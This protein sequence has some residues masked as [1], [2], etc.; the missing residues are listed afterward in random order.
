MVLLLSLYFPQFLLFN[1]CSQTFFCE[2]FVYLEVF[3]KTDYSLWLPFISCSILCFPGAIPGN[4][5]W[6]CLSDFLHFCLDTCSLFSHQSWFCYSAFVASFVK[7][8]LLLWSVYSETF[9]ILFCSG[10]LV[11][12]FSLHLCNSKN[13]NLF[14]QSCFCLQFRFTCFPLL[15]MTGGFTTVTQPGN[16][17]PAQTYN[18]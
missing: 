16:K 10:Q 13:K 3:G 1:R 14:L 6:V 5:V 17:P 12:F 9:Y 11:L 7:S 15:F 18:T 2:G 8:F 4:M